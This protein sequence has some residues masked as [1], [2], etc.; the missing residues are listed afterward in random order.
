MA[1]TL[2]IIKFNPEDVGKL[3]DIIMQHIRQLIL[4][5]KQ[6]QF[7]IE[8]KMVPWSNLKF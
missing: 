3:D 1:D 2:T 5:A 6:K 8:L 4:L 7:P